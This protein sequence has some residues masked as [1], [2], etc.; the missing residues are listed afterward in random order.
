[1]KRLKNT[2]NSE[3]LHDNSTRSLPNIINS[4]CN[5]R[6]GFSKNWQ[7]VLSNI[8]TDGE[9]RIKS[10]SAIRIPRS[11]HEDTYN[12]L[13]SQSSTA[14]LDKEISERVS[15]KFQRYLLKAQ[16]KFQNV[17]ITF[18]SSDR[19]Q[20]LLR[21]R[22]AVKTVQVL[23]R[24]TITDRQQAHRS[25]VKLVSWAQYQ[26]GFNG[27][28]QTSGLLKLSFDPGYYKAK[29]ESQV[30]NEA[31]IILSMDPSE[32]TEDQLR[33]A[34]VALT[35][36]VGAFG[37]F[38]IR[39]QQS[40]VRVGWY[41]QFEERRVIIRQGH[42]ADNF[43]FILSG[44][45]IVTI[46]ETNKSTG[47][48][49]GRTVAFLKKGGSF[50][51]LAL[52]HG[53]RRSATVTCKEDVEL[54]AVGRDDFI[55]IFM[56]VEKNKEPDHIQFIRTIGILRGWPFEMLPYHNPNICLFTFFRRDSILCRDSNACEWVYI[57]MTGSCRVF[58]AL[59]ATKPS[60]LCF[61]NP[62]KKISQEKK[63]PPICNGILNNSR[64]ACV[65]CCTKKR[66][67]NEKVRRLL[68]RRGLPSILQ[69]SQEESKY[70]E[71]YNY[72]HATLHS[73]QRSL[74]KSQASP[75]KHSRP[76]KVFVQIQKIG[77][78]EVFG[79]E[80]IVFDVIQQST[81]CTL[82]SDGA[83][84]ILINKKFFRQHLSDQVAKRI[85]KTIRPIP[86]EESLQKK[87]QVKTNWEAFK[88]MTLSKE[89]LHRK[90]LH[91]NE[92]LYY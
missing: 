37:E 30:S 38:P 83:E 61:E 55:D 46:L 16:R 70:D 17:V 57:I 45:A 73:Q 52:M 74:Q 56:H 36:A 26:L 90:M 80:P 49:Y 18:S 75:S 91:T 23:L 62:E 29:K 1:M 2:V 60:L 65:T 76:K 48:Q 13:K 7:E 85:R 12:G 21:F 86:T 50:G 10:Y 32:R 25:D 68:L 59:D 28:R 44:T 79:L 34:L 42:K 15:R 9:G 5:S 31:K 35:Q 63:L 67:R 39:M 27:Q 6:G 82:I 33:V 66:R 71:I 69:R 20:P 64:A 53:A 51:E 87:L 41:E 22:R 81:S 89:V 77:P 78:R 8:R 92:S 84:C 24:A 88:T 3:K 4:R 43:Y 54:L 72:N 14:L 19:V 47:E 11:D 58:K 40:L